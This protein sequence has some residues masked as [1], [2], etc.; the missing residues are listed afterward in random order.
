MDYLHG[1][2]IINQLDRK[3]LKLMQH[4]VYDSLKRDDYTI[5]VVIDPLDTHNWGENKAE[6]KYIS[7]ILSGITPFVSQHIAP[8]QMVEYANELP[9]GIHLIN[10]HFLLYALNN[11]ILAHIVKDAIPDKYRELFNTPPLDPAKISIFEFKD[12]KVYSIQDEEGMVRG[13][14]F[15]EIMRNIMSDFHNLLNYYEV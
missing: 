15:D 13:N 6:S 5:V 10:N 9:K 4:T 7:Q 8:G 1:L 12:G 2:G 3:I 14:T 11:R